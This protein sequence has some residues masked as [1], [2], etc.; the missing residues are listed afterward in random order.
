[1]ANSMSNRLVGF[2]PLVDRFVG[3]NLWGR[4]Y[5]PQICGAYNYYISIYLYIYVCLQRV[6]VYDESFGHLCVDYTCVDTLRELANSVYR[7][8]FAHCL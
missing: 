5:A 4:S 7:I 3:H 6:I 8:D 1:M 2:I